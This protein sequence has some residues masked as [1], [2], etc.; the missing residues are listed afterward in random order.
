ML[1]I[2]VGKDPQNDSITPYKTIQN[3][4]NFPKHTL[5][6]ARGGG[7]KGGGEVRP[8]PHANTHGFMQI[9]LHI[10]SDILRWYNS[11]FA[12]NN[13][14]FFFGRGKSDKTRPH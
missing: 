4:E 5:L 8:Y 13:T 14:G 7:G 12:F 11:C 10:K 1:R 9:N 2:S 3:P 6:K